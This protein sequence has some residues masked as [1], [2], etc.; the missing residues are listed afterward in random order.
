MRSFEIFSRK[1]EFS[2]GHLR[3]GITLGKW[4]GD[5]H[6]RIKGRAYVQAIDVVTFDRDG[7]KVVSL[8]G[9]HL[10]IALAF[11]S[12][13]FLKIE[14]TLENASTD[15]ITLEKLSL[16]IGD[17]NLNGYDNR[18]SFFKNGY[19]SWTITH[20]FF[21][22][23]R[24]MV[25]ILPPM[26]NMQDN[27]RNLPSKKRG[28]FTSDM[29]S[30]I[31]NLDKRVYLLI[32]Q[33][34]SFQHFLYVRCRFPNSRDKAPSLELVYDLGGKVL[35]A[36]SRLNLDRV[37]ILADSH[38]N[39][40]QDSYFDIIRARG[41]DTG[42]LPTGWCSWYYYFTRIKQDDVYENLNVAREKG[43]AWRYFVLDDGYQKAVGDWLLINN[44]FPEGLKAVSDR[45][46]AAGMAPGLWLAPFI[47]R[48]NSQLYQEH[49]EWILKDRKGKPALAGWN[50]NWGLGG[51]FYGMDVT[52]PGF[53]DYIS[54]VIDT[55]VHDW[56]YRYLKLDFV[57]AASLYGVAYDPTL[58]SAERLQLGYR[59]IR[60]AAGR[61]VFILGCGSPLSAAVGYVDAMRIGPDV[62]PYWFATY[63]YHLS[64]DPHALCTKFAIRSILNR[65]QMH[66][67]LW[68]NDPDCLLLRDS[69]TRLTSEER[70]SL[71]NAIIVSG[72]MYVLSDKLSLLSPETWEWMRDIDEMVHSCDQG[73][74][75]ALDYMERETPEL[76]YNSKGYLAVFNFENRI[77]HREIPFRFYLADILNE[78]AQFEDVWDGKRFSVDDGIMD[79]GE[80][81]PHSSRLL[82]VE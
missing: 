20:A 11:H 16:S 66:R 27:L 69:D 45:I 19:Q 12:N 18:Y 78:S 54:K 42:E 43:V 56:G 80:M 21:P 62:A 53:Q 64:R 63:R 73:R 6:Y 17:C 75:W 39:R 70:M 77:V 52:H 68:I 60:E 8:E 58:S 3:Y 30:V 25:P 2:L 5:L 50:P 48:R 4:S 9:D 79:M 65:C 47:A 55:A 40:I 49:N 7:T 74:A 13:G 36:G 32:G 31:G 10:R 29:F 33:A 15:A 28:E 44:K 82:R 51:N 23:E 34:E 71:A 57:Y 46:G 1:G 59:I 76:V 26:N 24:G 67:K 61:D 81:K 41:S 38:A 14:T 22:E 72:G 35:P 37:V